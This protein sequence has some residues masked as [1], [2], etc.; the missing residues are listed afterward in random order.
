MTELEYRTAGG[1]GKRIHM[2]VMH[3]EAPITSSMI[4]DGP[5][6]YAKLKEFKTRVL[7]DHAV[8]FF[9]SAEELARH[10]AEDLRVYLQRRPLA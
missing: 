1:S 4:E 3:P 2:Y 6:G 7:K 10:V 5:A 8:C 9:R